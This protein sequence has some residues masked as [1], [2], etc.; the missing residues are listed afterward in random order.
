MK[1]VEQVLLFLTLTFLPTKF[2][3]NFWPDFSLV[4]SLKVN[5]FSPAIYFWDILVLL[6]ICIFIFRQRRVNR[7]ALNLWMLFLFTSL[8]SLIPYVDSPI[9]LGPG[10]V[11]IQQYLTCGIF[12]IYL[13]ST[14]LLKYKAVFFWLLCLSSLWTVVAILLSNYQIFMADQISLIRR[15]ELS[16]I[17]VKLWLSS[18]IFGI[19][20]NNF[21]LYGVNDLVSGPTR[22]LQPV[23]NIFLLTAAET[24][25]VGL[26]GFAG[27]IGVPLF[28]I[29][30][31][32]KKSIEA[33]LLLI[34]WA[35][36]LLLGFLDHYFLTIPQGIR[37]LFLIWGLSIC[38]L[39]YLG[40]KPKED[41]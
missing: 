23:Y 28:G 36:I 17:A 39:E 29:W 3:Y 12:G 8:I 14:N 2:G 37:T 7:L 5:Y 13:A 35:T 19:G 1:K 26:L 15:I 16:E 34:V 31:L 11:R 40:A 22:F 41:L 10:L 9:N 25:I 33:K 4:Y 21:I 38:V 6:L 27:F 20:V 18:P 30:K 32:R 24:G